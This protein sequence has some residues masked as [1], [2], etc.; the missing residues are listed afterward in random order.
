MSSSNPDI[1][2]SNPGHSSASN[3]NDEYACNLLFNPGSV[4]TKWIR[5][6][7]DLGQKSQALVLLNPFYINPLKRGMQ[8]P[9]NACNGAMSKEQ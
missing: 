9:I 7:A 6:C 8:L 1:L 4:Y 2:G 3:S 5:R